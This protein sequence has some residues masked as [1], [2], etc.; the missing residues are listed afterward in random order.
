MEAPAQGPG[1]ARAAV[2]KWHR[3]GVSMTS[4]VSARDSGGQMQNQPAGRGGSTE[5]WEGKLV[6]H[7]SPWLADGF[8]LAVCCCAQQPPFYKIT[9]HTELGPV[10]MTLLKTTASVKTLSLNKATCSR[11]GD[12]TFNRFSLGHSIQPQTRHLKHVFQ[13]KN[14]RL[15]YFVLKSIF[16]H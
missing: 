2:T 14:L 7:L 6:G 5:G 9:V 4:Y 13:R 11:T 1:A 16:S 15:F 12:Y 10:L 8:L 3:L